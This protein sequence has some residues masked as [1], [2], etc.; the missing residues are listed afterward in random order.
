MVLQNIDRSGYGSSSFDR[1]SCGAAHMAPR[2][3]KALFLEA[4]RR[5]EP[6]TRLAEQHRVSRKFI[7]QQMEKATTAIDQAFQ[8]AGPQENPVLFRL[9]VTQDWLEQ[10]VLS[11]TLIC[12]SS[13]RGVMELLETMFDYRQIS[14][15]SIH[16]L[17]MQ[18]VDKARQFHAAEDLS[19][20]RVGAHDEIYQARQPVLVGM[21]V[22]STYCYLLEAVDHCDETTWGVGGSWITTGLYDCRRGLG[23]AGRPTSGVGGPALPRRC[24]PSRKASARI[25]HLPG[26]SCPCVYCG[27]SEDPT[28]V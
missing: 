4:L 26:S 23:A 6:L 3:R 28:Q 27:P 8:P 18:A 13:Y 15:G 11:L 5:T 14:L 22:V 16:N 7:Y 2:Q 10:L 12:H 19:S 21:D 1:D 9:P 20:I 25:V 24:L 17:L